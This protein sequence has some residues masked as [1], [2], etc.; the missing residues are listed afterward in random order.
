[1]KSP[2]TRACRVGVCAK[3]I[4]RRLRR[5]RRGRRCRGGL[6]IFGVSSW[7]IVGGAAAR[8][9]SSA[10]HPAVA[11]RVS[12]KGATGPGVRASP[13]PGGAPRRR[14]PRPPACCPGR[15]EPPRRRVLAALPPPLRE[16]GPAATTL[17][18]RVGAP[19]LAL[20]GRWGAGRPPPAALAPVPG[21]WFAGLH[22][23]GRTGHT[24]TVAR[25]PLAFLALS[26]SCGCTSGAG[27]A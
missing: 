23:G 1:M 5:L 22:H 25:R 8:G 20:D 13:P 19:A 18:P 16:V 2:I 15:P 21:P 6:A 9:R 11:N 26:S 10:P 24:R 12:L 14:P 17:G 27:P 3:P 4:V 7:P